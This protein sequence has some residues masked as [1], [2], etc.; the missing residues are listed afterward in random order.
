MNDKTINFFECTINKSTYRFEFIDK[1]YFT[2][3]ISFNH[4][5]SCEINSDGFHKKFLDELPL[6]IIYC[7]TANNDWF[8]FLDL[9]IFRYIINL[10]INKDHELI[11]Y[12][13][14]MGGYAALFFSQI[15]KGSKVIALSPQYTFDSS[16]MSHERRWIEEW[17]ILYPHQRIEKNTI[18]RDIWVIY[19]EMNIGD[20]DHADMI[21]SNMD[22]VNTLSFPFAGHPVGYALNRQGIL[23]PLLSN[24]FFSSSNIESKSYIESWKANILEDTES[25]NNYFVTLSKEDVKLFLCKLNSPI[26][27]KFI[28]GV[29]SQ[30]AFDIGVS[31]LSHGLEN[32]ANLFFDISTRECSNPHILAYVAD[33]Y[34]KQLKVEKAYTLISKAISILPNNNVFLKIENNVK[35]KITLDNHS[36]NIFHVACMQKN[37]GSLLYTWAFYWGQVAG[38]ENIIILDNGSTDEETITILKLLELCGIKIEY[39]Y[40]GR[41][42]FEKKGLCLLEALRNNFSNDNRAILV[43]CDEFYY[44]FTNK[45]VSFNPRIVKDSIIEDIKDLSPSQVLRL[46]QGLLNVPN[47]TNAYCWKPKRVLL[48]LHF[49]SYIDVGMHLY[50]WNDGIDLH[51][52]SYEFKSSNRL[53]VMH[54]HNCFFKELVKKAK[55]KL[56]DRVVSFSKEDL[57]AYRGAGSHLV[58]YLLMSESEY[59]ESF[60]NL[61]QTNIAHSWNDTNLDFP[62]SS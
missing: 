19:D 31:F 11:F 54:F 61:D 52:A 24:L 42:H 6:N 5:N 58:K 55:E 20:K 45:I 4:H 56:K 34:E 51:T 39:G 41:D 40:R 15:F 16:I 28:E 21:V 35:N 29:N 14:S 48:P 47:S 44:S 49:N 22:R 25:I 23:K 50:D 37:E 2:T 30:E 38:F 27:L 3:I 43:D 26:G 59:L 32:L 53:G 36:N 9:D 1:G 7:K 10:F 57:L 33:V 18:D 13:S 62:Y 8:H 46:D 12:G 17:H 60:D